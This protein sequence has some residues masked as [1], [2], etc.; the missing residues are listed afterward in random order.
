MLAILLV[1]N[2]RNRF[3]CLLGQ[4]NFLLVL[5]VNLTGHSFFDFYVRFMKI[6]SMKRS[7]LHPTCYKQSV[8]DPPPPKTTH[9]CLLTKKIYKF[10]I[11]IFRILLLHEIPQ[12]SIISQNFFRQKI[13]QKKKNWEKRKHH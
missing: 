9:H 8:Y 4:V 3:F 13:K 11:Q 6:S 7:Y 10:F 2:Q 12:I 1:G 5:L